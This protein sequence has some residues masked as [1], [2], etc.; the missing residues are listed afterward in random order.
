[1]QTELHDK[2]VA[3]R[4]WLVVASNSFYTYLS[5]L[6]NFLSFYFFIC[7]GTVKAEVLD[8]IPNLPGLVS[9]PVYDIEPVHFLSVCCNTIKWVQKTRQ[10]YDPET[11]MVC[12]ANFFIWML[13]ILTI[14][15]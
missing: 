7:R 15:K 4:I 2:K 6:N 10:V 12:D 11:K 8:G 14:I 3:D 9:V 5:S 1:M 13:M